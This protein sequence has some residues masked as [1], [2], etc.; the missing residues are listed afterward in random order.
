MATMRTLLW[1]LLLST[2]MALVAGSGCSGK[3]SCPAGQQDCLGTCR[4]FQSDPIACG[5][6]GHVCPTGASCT[7]GACVCPQGT[8][9][10]GNACV[11]LQTSARNCG[12][13]SHDC[14][15]GTC[16]AE[17]CDCGGFLN[18]DPAGITSPQ[19]VDSQNDRR[20][21]GACGHDCGVGT[22][23][24]GS[25]VCTGFNDCGATANPQCRDTR[26]DRLN[27]GACGNT[28]GNTAICQNSACFD[29]TS[30]TTT[31]NRCSNSCTNLQTDSANCGTCGHAC[32]GAQVCSAGQ[33]V[34]PAG[35]TVCLGACVDTQTDAA[36]CGGCGKRCPTGQACAG[37]ACACT[38][39]PT[40]SNIC[41]TGGNGC[42]LTGCQI[43]HDTGFQPVTG[44][45]QTFFDCNAAGSAAAA[46]AAAEHF[47]AGTPVTGI[48][49]ACVFG[50]S[51]GNC[52]AWQTLGTPQSCGVW[53]FTGNVA[54]KATVTQG[55]CLCPDSTFSVDWH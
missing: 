2:S 47:A 4:D 11:D 41:C 23:S 5:S 14:G 10:C 36:N 51:T 15:V 33:C 44:Q 55:P 49:G 46:R 50:E 38:S 45:G 26:A 1:L 21:C 22:C 32:S 40:C 20:N 18:C 31:P 16:G 29:C 3:K 9:E 37:G 35:K 27:C 48:Q 17:T 6:C 12:A 24:T 39:G 43:E 25:C 54:G 34:C 30:T 53:C 13:C 7:A 28:C 52:V 8:T 42:C 19:C